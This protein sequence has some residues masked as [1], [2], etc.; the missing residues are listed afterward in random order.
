[1][2]LEMISLVG[3]MALS[4]WPRMKHA[5]HMFQQNRY[6][7]PRYIPWV[8]QSKTTWALFFSSLLLGLALV[9]SVVIDQPWVG[10]LSYLLV[11]FGSR[12]FKRKEK[13]VKPLFT[14]HVLNVKSL[15][16]TH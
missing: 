11:A 13:F 4:L 2:T 5:L 12:L 6:E 10:V 9:M 16:S 7:H 3:A 1:M 14:H 15:S 8:L